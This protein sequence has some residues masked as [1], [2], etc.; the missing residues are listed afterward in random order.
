MVLALALAASAGEC[1][2]LYE[3]EMRQLVDASYAILHADRPDLS[4]HAGLSRQLENRLPCAGFQVTEALW[5]RYLVG[6]AIREYPDG[7]WTTSLT[8]ALRT[9]PD[10]EIPVRPDHPMRAWT[11]A[12]AP[13]PQGP[14]PPHL[15][16][17]KDGSRLA[18]QLPL[19]AIHLL[20]RPQEESFETMVVHGPA[21]IPEGWLKPPRLSK[22]MRQTRRRKAIHVWG[23]VG[24]ATLLV[25]G[26]ASLAVGIGA[27]KSFQDPATPDDEL[28]KYERR[29]DKAMPLG[30]MFLGAGAAGLAATWIVRW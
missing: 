6:V 27:Q 15:T 30:A 18:Y 28:R 19:D 23:T 26:A 29:N 1:P 7:D 3:L 10:A 24:A 13:P 16:I 4:A 8:T 22:S 5:S 17:F 21:T 12:P 2:A 25:G 9:D 14:L 11:P 20:Q